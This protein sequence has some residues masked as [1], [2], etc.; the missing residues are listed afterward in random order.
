MQK[1]TLKI[2]LTTGGALPV[3]NAVIRIKDTSGKA[4]YETRIPFLAGGETR[5]YDLDVP[6]TAL[7]FEENGGAV[8]YGV[9]NAEVL[10]PGFIP[11]YIR[12]I[13]VFPD[14]EAL[15]R[16]NMLPQAE[17]FPQP[18]GSERINIPPNAL[19]L[20]PEEKGDES[21]LPPRNPTPQLHTTPFIPEYITVHL[22]APTDLSARNVTVTFQDYIKNVASSEIYPTWPE[23]ALKANILAQ[24]SFTL[25]RVFTEWYRSRGYNFDITNTTAFDQYFVDGRNIFDNISIYKY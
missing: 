24:I 1:G 19:R 17:S 16:I 15:L 5:A 10:S 2:E 13:Q 21:T 14:R 22:G 20:P 3:R 11:Q 23:E 12:G 6:D 8:P 4:L 7:S 9:Y 18:V 25:N